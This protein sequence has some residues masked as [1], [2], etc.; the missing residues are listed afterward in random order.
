MVDVIN[1]SATP[2]TIVVDSGDRHGRR[3]HGRAADHLAFETMTTAKDVLTNLN[4]HG[5][6]MDDKFTGLSALVADAQF[7]TLERFGITDVA[8]ERNGGDI[9]TLIAKVAGEITT[10]ATLNAKDGIIDSAKNAAA[11]T[12]L[13][14]QNAAAA[15]AQLAECCCELKVGQRDQADRILAMLTDNERRNSD[16][17]ET[18]LKIDLSNCEQLEKIRTAILTGGVLTAAKSQA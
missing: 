16:R 11:A 10:Q 14:V 12:L 13:A 9:R 6:R 1:P 5:G 7:R 3:D 15:A 17:R 8:V 2:A 4:V 18:N